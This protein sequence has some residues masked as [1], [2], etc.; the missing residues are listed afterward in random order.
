MA[1]QVRDLKD[2][3]ALNTARFEN[4]PDMDEGYLNTDGTPRVWVIKPLSPA[5]EMAV[6]RARNENTD[7]L[8]RY[9]SYLQSKWEFLQKGESEPRPSGAEVSDDTDPRVLAEQYAPIVAAMV[10]NVEL[11]PD[12]LIEKFHGMLLKFIVEDTQDFF[13]K[14]DER[15]GRPKKK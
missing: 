5:R 2:F 13:S 15:M 9:I 11:D 6:E 4:V 3:I 7:H 14:V 1:T 10:S 12:D 8:Q